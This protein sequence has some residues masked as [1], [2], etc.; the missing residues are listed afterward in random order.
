MGSTW[1]VRANSFCYLVIG[2]IALSIHRA[3]RFIFPPSAFSSQPKI[4]SSAFNFAFWKS[5]NRNR[6]PANNTMIIS[7]LAGSR[8]FSLNARQARMEPPKVSTRAVILIMRSCFS[9]PAPNARDSLG[10]M[11]LPIGYSYQAANDYQ[12]GAHRVFFEE[13]Q[14]DGTHHQ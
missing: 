5:S 12:G 13:Q 8:I 2:L 10:F 9:F 14:T 4:C 1:R 3:S 6:M 11:F 7:L